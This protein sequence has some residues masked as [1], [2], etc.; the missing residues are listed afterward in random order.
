MQ[1]FMRLLHSFFPENGSEVELRAIAEL[2]C[3]TLYF[4]KGLKSVLR[5]L[6]D[7]INYIRKHK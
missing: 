2:A 1:L 5:L 4:L 7:L 3:L 6:N